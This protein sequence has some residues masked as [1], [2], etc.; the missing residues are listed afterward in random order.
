MCQPLFEAN[1]SSRGQAPLPSDKC[2][3]G[4]ESALHFRQ[5]LEKDTMT[6]NAKTKK[7]GIVQKVI[8]SPHEPEK[9]QIAVESADHLYKEIRIENTFETA[10][11][12]TVK[13]K[14]GS[15]VEVTVEADPKE[16][17]PKV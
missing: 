1:Y 3:S 7:P 12:E 10:K 5:T 16:T 6:K 13:L 15:H 17:V 11:G 2:A 4:P 8:K 14:E 9:V